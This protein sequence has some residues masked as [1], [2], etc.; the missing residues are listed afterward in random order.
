MNW[1]VGGE[2]RSGVEGDGRSDVIGGGMRAWGGVM[3]SIY[4]S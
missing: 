2:S 1:A 3:L 4:N